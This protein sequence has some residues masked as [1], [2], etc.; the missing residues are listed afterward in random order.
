VVWDRATGRKVCEIPLEKRYHP[1]SALAF[2]ADGKRVYAEHPADAHHEWA[3]D[4]TTG[5]P[6]DLPRPHA[7]ARA[8]AF[9]AG[10]REAIFQRGELF[11]RWDVEKAEGLV[12][13]TA[14]FRFPV[15]ARLGD[16]LL[17]AGR[18]QDEVAVWDAG[19]NAQL[20]RVGSVRVKNIGGPPPAFSADGTLVAAPTEPPVVAVYDA[21]TGRRV[22]LMDADG[23]KSYWSLAFSPDKQTLAGS[24]HDGSVRLWNLADGRERA[25]VRAFPGHITNVFFAPDSKTFATGFGNNAHGVMLWDTAT[26]R[27]VEPY[28]SHAAPVTSV[29]FA[30]GGRLVATSSFMR[31]DP[32]VRLWEPDTGKLVRTLDSGVP[33]GVP[34]VAFS[35]DGRTLAAASW[36]FDRKVRLWDVA[37]G[38]LRHAMAGH[39][40]GCTCLVFSADGKRIATG[41]SYGSTSRENAGR[42]CVWDADA[43]KLLRELRGARGSVRRVAFT[44]DGKHVLAAA[45]GVFVFDTETGQ[46]VGDPIADGKR[47]WGLSVAPDGRHLAT[48]DEHGRLRVWEFPSRRQVPFASPA[49]KSVNVAF[50]PD[51]RTLAV[52]REG[53][54]VEVRRVPTG[55]VVGRL[56]GVPGD[57]RVFFS[58]DGR[59]L[60]TAGN[61]ESSAVVWEISAG[62]V[63]R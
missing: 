47:L 31:G 52:I 30:P 54:E 16:R 28:P 57:R 36:D 18:E 17:V 14:S 4:A 15:A 59:R 33:A 32:V 51:G 53:G 44:P 1:P 46:A 26:G 7:A 62:G 37:T 56:A 12:G 19:R 9:P 45:E 11:L 61:E 10:G 49:G 20:W 3:W 42:V 29:A 63:G 6:L 39:E 55:E 21:L 23:E 24:N 25:R 60:A 27:P 41:D 50:A 2:S 8:I 43:G 35:P 58:P 48:T 22:R 40:A 34:A 5:Q 38:A 13:G